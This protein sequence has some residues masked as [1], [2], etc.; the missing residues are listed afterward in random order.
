ME[1]GCPDAGHG[2]RFVLI[3]R[4]GVGAQTRRHS[5]HTLTTHA[6]RT[7]LGGS[8]GH[9]SSTPAPVLIIHQSIFGLTFALEESGWGG[10]WWSQR[11]PQADV[12]GTTQ[13]DPVQG[14]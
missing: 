5:L 13:G 7:T 1:E 10:V 14:S 12:L 3:T 9:S 11:T 2:A 4:Y 8:Y 6:L